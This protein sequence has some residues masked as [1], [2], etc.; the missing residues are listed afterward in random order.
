MKTIM[1][2]LILLV[3]F[4]CQ[5]D[6]SLNEFEEEQIASC[7]LIENHTNASSIVPLPD[8]G[9][10]A[11]WGWS[12]TKMDAQDNEE[13]TKNYFP[14][15][16][17]HTHTRLNIVLDD[18]GGFI[19]YAIGS[20]DFVDGNFHRTEIYFYIIK[21]DANG[22]TLWENRYG[23]MN[24][25]IAA[26]P[27]VK[28]LPE[29]G[30][31]LLGHSDGRSEPPYTNKADIYLARLDE[32]G[33]EIW[34]RSYGEMEND[35]KGILIEVFPGNNGF[36]VSGLSKSETSKE[37]FLAHFD[38]E[39]NEKWYKTIGG[40]EL[41]ENGNQVILNMPGEGFVLG[42]DKD[43]KGIIIH[44]YDLEGNEI[45]T[46]T[47]ANGRG[48]FE[49]LEHIPNEGFLIY[50]GICCGDRPNLNKSYLIRTDLNANELWS[51]TY[52][53]QLMVEDVKR[54]SDGTLIFVTRG[55]NEFLLHHI[56][57]NG[58][59]LSICEI[60]SISSTSTTS[61][62]TFQ[63]FGD[64]ELIAFIS[65]TSFSFFGDGGWWFGDGTGT[66]GFNFT[67]NNK[68]LRIALD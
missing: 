33:Q 41:N 58:E 38:L 20:H 11:V 56:E 7:D 25:E 9:Y 55:I 39:G 68:L 30:Y 47:F 10:L 27:R 67:S 48:V 37:F 15:D 34:N 22:N 44:K 6:Q 24:G 21:T 54:L 16:T 19:L 8:R 36:M 26:V 42:L 63:N 1:L 12:V 46:K 60:Y 65:E 64:G 45:W 49:G 5:K 2:L 43:D 18:D 62:R 59:E 40:E 66:G 35:D 13:W 50:G 32:T 14:D 29:G 61:L 28:V 57:G 53:E 31:L 52:E 17:T 23:E 4:S 51:R 3:S